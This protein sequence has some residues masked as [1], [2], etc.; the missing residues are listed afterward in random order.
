VRRTPV[1]QRQ[2][3]ETKQV[4]TV[5]TVLEVRE[6]L[7][8]AAET[9]AEDHPDHPAG[10]VLRC[11]ARAVRLVRLRGCPDEQLPETAR[12]LAAETLTSGARSVAGHGAGFASRHTDDA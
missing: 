6:Q 1:A 11:Y 8:L 5:E 10:S 7:L 3:A 4:A 12:R 2:Q 9:L